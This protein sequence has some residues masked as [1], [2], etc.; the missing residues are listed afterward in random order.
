MRG[1]GLA[2]L[3]LLCAAASECPAQRPPWLKEPYLRPAV[4]GQLVDSTTGQPA[5][6]VGLRV[7]DKYGFSSADSLGWYLLFDLPV[8]NREIEFLCPSRRRFAGRLFARRSLAV[9]PTT[10]SLLTIS[11]PMGGCAEPPEASR[12]AEFAGFY[13]EGFEESRFVPCPR[14]P[15]LTQS[16]AGTAYEGVFR[17]DIWVDLDRTV[18]EQGPRWPTLR[19][20]P[21]ALFFVR[22]RGKLTG[23]GAYGHLGVS[24][25]RLQ[26]AEVIEVRAPRKGDCR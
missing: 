17:P 5:G 19:G 25:F 1:P 18:R 21:Y 22:W 23:P 13:S 14:P 7:R 24:F 11:L 12:D 20:D 6:R 3:L 8:G 26:V 15:E 16:F 4:F 9:S 2:G 10:D